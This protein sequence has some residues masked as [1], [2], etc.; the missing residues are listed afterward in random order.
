MQ[1]RRAGEDDDGLKDRIALEGYYG[2]D[3]AFLRVK[4][5]VDVPNSVTYLNRTP[6]YLFMS[7][8]SINVNPREWIEV[9]IYRGVNS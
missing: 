8:P 3:P 1:Q 2:L 4:C 5:K 9:N 6:C 7:L